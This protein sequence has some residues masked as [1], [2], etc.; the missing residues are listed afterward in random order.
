VGR[1]VA[2]ELVLTGDLITA[3]RAYEIGL[4]NR[5]VPGAE[6][7]AAAR[8]IAKKI[9]SRGPVA[10]RMAKMAMNRGLDMDLPNGCALEA[11]LFAAVFAT[12]DRVEGITAFI[13]KRKPD[14][15]GK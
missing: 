4:V 11:S 10:V 6:L 1:N 7:M 3:Q 13:G 15:Q 9:L 5:V 14:F 8:E 2:K 12:G